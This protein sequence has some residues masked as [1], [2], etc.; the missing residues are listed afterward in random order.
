MA[1]GVLKIHWLSISHTFLYQFP[2]LHK[3]E[4][5]LNKLLVK[6]DINGPNTYTGNYTVI[7]FLDNGI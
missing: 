3:A 6:K 1:Y 7:T 2:L 4:M 5:A